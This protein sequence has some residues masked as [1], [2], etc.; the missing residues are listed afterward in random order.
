MMALMLRVFIYGVLGAAVGLIFGTAFGGV[1]GAILGAIGCSM[2]GLYI[3]KY[4]NRHRI[5]ERPFFVE[6]EIEP[7]LDLI[8]RQTLSFLP[9]AVSVRVVSFLRSVL[10]RWV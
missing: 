4:M 8:D 7:T 1:I 3:A 5:L 2:I 9:A 6:S 10:E